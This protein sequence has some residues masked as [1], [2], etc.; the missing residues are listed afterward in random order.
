MSRMHLFLA[1]VAA[2]QF[3]TSVPTAGAQV[4]LQD[5]TTLVIAPLPRTSAHA[6]A[7]GRALAHAR[8]AV[9]YSAGDQ[10]GV[11]SLQQALDGIEWRPYDYKAGHAGEFAGWL[12]AN[13]LPAS[14]GR[15]VLVL[16][17]DEVIAPVLQRATGV[18]AGEIARIESDDLFVVTVSPNY[19]SLVRSKLS[20]PHE[21]QVAP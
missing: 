12:L 11:P 14:P 10:S 7:L 20:V 15:T 21:P 16:A 9:L 4:E 8:V 17:P 6:D 2:I 1:L 18:D 3:L 5:A 13:V 19:A